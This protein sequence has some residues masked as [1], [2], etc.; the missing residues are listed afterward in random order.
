MASW[1]HVIIPISADPGPVMRALSL[2]VTPRQGGLAVVAGLLAAAGFWPLALWPLL[3]V[4]IALFLRLLRDQDVQTARNLGLVYGLTYAAGTMYWM[5]LIFGPL[6][7]PLLAL[8]AAYFGLFA[9]LIALTR[10]LRVPVRAALVALFAVA[11]EWLRG[12]AWYLRFPWYTPPHALAALPPMAAGV[13]WLGT[14][15]LS[16]VV[17]LIAAAGA[18]GRPWNWGAF[19]LLPAAWLLLPADGTPDRRVLLLQAEYFGRAAQLIPKIPEEKVDLAVLPE[20]A[21]APDSP[22]S[23]LKLSHGPAEL[24]RKTSSPVVFGAEER[25]PGEKEESNVAAVIDS[26][27]RLLGTFP[28]QHPVPLMADGKPGD[29]RPLF[30]V[31]D[32]V[33][34]VAI[35]YDFDAPE[36]VGSLVGA[37][38]T[39][40]VA[41]TL[42]AMSWSRAQHEHHEMLFRLRALEN[43]RWLLRS[44]SSGRTEVISPSGW[45]SQEG[46]EIGKVGHIVLPFAHRGS[47]SLGGRLAFL[48]PAALAATGLF[49]VGRGVMWLRERRRLKAKARE[50][51]AAGQLPTSPAP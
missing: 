5:F 31:D 42:D 1:R 41:P 25:A 24:A 37:G 19:L 40:L 35:C 2:G 11:I 22:E 9:T 13:R 29:R 38:A 33:L 6:A 34:G 21:F 27:G 20:L 28:K 30:P 23:A 50:V 44:A 14:Y 49:V 36:V 43:D 15:G 32:G 8:M 17:W 18:F 39:V 45:P 7:I 10:G 48:G 16:F 26:D 51:A 46:I 12:D 47:W 3:L 4:S